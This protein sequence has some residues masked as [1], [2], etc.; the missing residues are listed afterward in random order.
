VAVAVLHDIGRRDQ[1]QPWLRQHYPLREAGPLLTMLQRD[2][3]CPAT[4]SMGRLFDAAAGL[5]GVR[6]QNH[7]EGQAAMELEG[8]AQKYGPV[9]PASDGFLLREDVLDFSPLLAHLAQCR[10]PEYGASWFHVTVAHGLAQWVIAAA[11]RCQLEQVAVGGGCAMNEVLMGHLR[12]ALPETGIRL[13]EA[14][15]APPN[16]GGLALGQAW[17]ARLQ[18]QRQGR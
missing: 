10:D 6:D 17:I 8:L 4:T 16:D 1:I 5:L 2:V 14:Q 3:H 9:P 15:R 13:Y 7:Y 11:R 18:S 12:G